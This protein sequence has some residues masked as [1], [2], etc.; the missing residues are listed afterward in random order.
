[1]IGMGHG[2]IAHTMWMLAAVVAMVAVSLVRHKIENPSPPPPEGATQVGDDQAKRTE[3]ETGPEG[4]VDHDG[5]EYIPPEDPDII[6]ASRVG[7][8]EDDPDNPA[9][10]HVYWVSRA[11]WERSRA[12]PDEQLPRWR[13]WL[14]I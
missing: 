11:A 2:G 3:S 13:V 1:V 12:E 9:R 5:N 4:D 6:T 8:H 14:G 7:W 10:T